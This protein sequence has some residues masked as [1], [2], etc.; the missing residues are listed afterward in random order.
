MRSLVGMGLALTVFPQLDSFVDRPD[1][2][3]KAIRHIFQHLE[4]TQLWRIES[5]EDVAEAGEPTG[6]RDSNSDDTESAD[7]DIS[8]DEDDSK[9]EHHLWLKKM[10][11]TTVNDYLAQELVLQ[12]GIPEAERF[13]EHWKELYS[14]GL[15]SFMPLPEWREQEDDA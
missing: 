3:F 7:N 14:E 8:D 9:S 4:G 1:K 11:E 15:I 5:G 12:L 13:K 10:P 2:L 6:K